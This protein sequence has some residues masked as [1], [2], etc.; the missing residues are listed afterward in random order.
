MSELRQQPGVARLVQQA[1]PA[2]YDHLLPCFGVHLFWWTPHAPQ[3]STEKGAEKFALTDE[4]LVT[5]KTRRPHQGRGMNGRTLLKAFC[6]GLKK[7]AAPSPK[8][9]KGGPLTTSQKQAQ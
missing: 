5:Y 7:S 6:D 8:K 9:Q 2:V 1:L 3:N 4:W